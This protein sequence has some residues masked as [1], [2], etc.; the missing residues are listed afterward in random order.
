M[1]SS[2]ASPPRQW[3]R[4]ILRRSPD[5][6]DVNAADVDARRQARTT[7]EFN[8]ERKPWSQDVNAARL[9]LDEQVTKTLPDYA[10]FSDC[11]RNTQAA[12]GSEDESPIYADLQNP[13]QQLKTLPPT[14]TRVFA[15]GKNDPALRGA[16]M[17]L[18]KALPE[19]PAHVDDALRRIDSQNAGALAVAAGIRGSIISQM[20][21]ADPRTKDQALANA[22]YPQQLWRW[23]RAIQENWI[24][25]DVLALVYGVNVGL[26]V[27]VG[28]GIAVINDVYEKAQAD[29]EV[30]KARTAQTAA[31]SWE[32][33]SD[34]RAAEERA[35]KWNFH[36]L[37]VVM[38]DGDDYVVLEN[39]AGD[40]A[41]VNF[42]DTYRW[43]FKIFGP[44]LSVHE[45]SRSDTHTTE[46]YLTLGFE[47]TATPAAPVGAA[48]AQ[49]VPL[50]ADE[51]ADLKYN[52]SNQMTVGKYVRRLRQLNPHLTQ[53]DA[54]TKIAE[55]A[56]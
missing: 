17:W 7:D 49:L 20:S 22:D 47:R 48:P 30:D 9:A 44:E 39:A 55:M 1:R 43:R 28:D 4:R 37:P 29:V 51:L 6:Q 42:M 31:E 10:T 11:H 2:E 14:E 34:A 32:D 38:T 21:I 27:R 25:S 50:S 26:N 33:L 40:I 3:R 45:A 46:H 56:Q 41:N 35:T 18:A 8:Q 53:A 52:A 16:F 23:Y 19:F 54:R 5:S 36:W 15:T 12:M 13:R 24:T